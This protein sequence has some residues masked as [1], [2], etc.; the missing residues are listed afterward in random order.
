M[1][2]INGT[3]SGSMKRDIESI[4]Y[5]S[6]PSI[7]RS[8][9]TDTVLY[10]VNYSNNAGFALLGATQ[11]SE[12]IYAISADGKLQIED[13]TFNKGLQMF[14]QSAENHATAMATSGLVDV[15][16]IYGIKRSCGV[17]FPESV[18]KWNQT[19]PYNKY[20][21]TVNG[22]QGY[23]GCG[24]LAAGM[25]MAYYK[26]P[27]SIN[28]RALNWSNI[29]DNNNTDDIA[30][31]LEDLAGANFLNSQYL[32]STSLER[33][34]YTYSFKTTFTKCFYNMDECWNF[35]PFE[36]NRVS[37]F[38]FIQK[39]ISAWEKPTP[40]LMFGN[41]ISND[42][43]VG[44]FWIVDGFIERIRFIG[45][46][47]ITSEADPMLHILWGWG[48]NGNGYY[49]YLLSD[50]HLNQSLYNGNYTSYPFGSLSVFGKIYPTK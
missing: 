22:K 27:T 39:G 26:H 49:L 9:V 10:L 42:N 29:V 21:P 41:C 6:T 36:N 28:G 11:N 47:D 44:H 20:C 32:S 31:F 30:R 23:V 18:A 17:D 2:S 24:A 4:Q 50:H 45:N 35:Y 33:T 38:D 13:T 25:L 37:I 12:D 43:Y 5:L 7:T 46:S 15:S 34:T 19:A 14:I 40:I 8:N 1:D 16:Y 3:R 48:G